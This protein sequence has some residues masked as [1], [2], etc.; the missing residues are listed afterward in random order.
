MSVD[1]PSVKGKDNFRIV[2]DQRGRVSA[3][4]PKNEYDN[5]MSGLK[6]VDN[7]AIAVSD[8]GV[9]MVSKKGTIPIMLIKLMAG[10]L[11][12]KH[13]TSS[14][15]DGLGRDNNRAVTSPDHLDLLFSDTE[16]RLLFVDREVR[17]LFCPKSNNRELWK[18]T[19]LKE[20]PVLGM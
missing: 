9:A 2:A 12:I 17:F 1:S 15:W 11:R 5:V 20:I 3:E 6:G 7:W 18:Y 8:Y 16:N 13:P 19:I 10:L 14:Q 4:T